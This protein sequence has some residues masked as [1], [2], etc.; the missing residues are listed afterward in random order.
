MPQRFLWRRKWHVVARQNE[1]FDR[2]A[3]PERSGLFNYTPGFCDNA[4]A[5]KIHKIAFL[6]SKF[7]LFDFGSDGVDIS[8]KTC[9]PIAVHG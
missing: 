7:R 9:A 1:G 4:S 6:N 8:I 2:V 3:T 5:D